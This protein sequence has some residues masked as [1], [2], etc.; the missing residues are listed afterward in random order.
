[1]PLTL[2]R[3]GFLKNIIVVFT[4]ASLANFLNLL[5]QL[6]IAHR[7]P[8]A[9]F[10]SFNSLLSVFSIVSAPLSVFG[11]GVARQCAEFKARAQSEALKN[12]VSALLVR[13][14][15]YAALTVFLFWLVS[16][17]ALSLLHIS[18]TASGILLA[19]LL[20]SMWLVPVVSGAVQGL[21]FFRWFSLGSVLSGI[22]K[23]ALALVFVGI[24]LSV[25]GALGAFVAAQTALFLLY[26]LPL[27]SFLRVRFHSS[28]PYRELLVSLLPFAA[29]SACFIALV[30]SDM[31]MVKLFFNEQQSGVYSI[32]QMIGKIFLFLP[33]PVSMVMFPRTSSLNAQ[34]R[35]TFSV[36]RRSLGYVLAVCIVAAIVYNSM[37]CVIL[38]LLT[39]KVFP[40]SV[41]LGRLFGVSM[42]F[43]TLGYVL[44]SYF[45]S[46]GDW[47]FLPWL[48]AAT[49]AQVVI[50]YLYHPT[51]MHVQAIMCATS[52]LLF[53]ALVFLA[54]RKVLAQVE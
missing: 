23:I 50:L 30:S 19:V 45:L 35:E 24:G 27:R 1:M 21:E 16:F 34:G 15:L 47:R 53:A 18:S 38:K 52:A 2:K 37:P 51:L 49:T 14:T 31:V 17:K 43:Y 12:W 40:E 20:A 42:S 6:L 4:G 28:S 8:A 39:G 41:A 48:G 29:S 11:L 46:L 7:L 22:V 33:G 54:R 9:D 32:A 26:L 10:A 44:I 36:V 3:D 13:H 25:S 5:Y